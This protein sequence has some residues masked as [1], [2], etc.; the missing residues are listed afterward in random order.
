MKLISTLKTS[1]SLSV[2]RGDYNEKM[3]F[4]N[5]RLFCAIFL[6]Q[7]ACSLVTELIG[8]KIPIKIL[9]L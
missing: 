2:V 1:L 4:L 3:Y 6:K 5:L 8:V 9:A 7:T